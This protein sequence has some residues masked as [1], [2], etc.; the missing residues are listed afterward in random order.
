MATNNRDT[1]LDGRPE[2]TS[3]LP[4][5]DG[6]SGGAEPDGALDP[7]SAPQTGL[8]PDTAPDAAGGQDTSTAADTDPTDVPAERA[9]A[10]TD[11]SGQIPLGDPALDNEEEM[12]QAGADLQSSREKTAT[13]RISPIG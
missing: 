7:D 9:A 1:D 3:T 12:Q 6:T 8:D 4:S 11:D 2:M 5:G 10:P 13:A